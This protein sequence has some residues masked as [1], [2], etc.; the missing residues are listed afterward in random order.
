MTGFVEGVFIIVA[1]GASWKALLDALQAAPLGKEV[2]TGC[3]DLLQS[4]RPVIAGTSKDEVEDD[5]GT[6]TAYAWT[7]RQETTPFLRPKYFGECRA[8]SV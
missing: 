3:A 7:G 6:D 2:L 8:L 4:L 1:F 5:L